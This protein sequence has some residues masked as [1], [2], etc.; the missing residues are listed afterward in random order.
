MEEN[1]ISASNSQSEPQKQVSESEKL[2]MI[3][4]ILR[5]KPRVETIE[6]TQTIEHDNEN[7]SHEKVEEKQ[8]MPHVQPVQVVKQ[9]PISFLLVC[10]LMVVCF[11]TGYLGGYFYLYKNMPTLDSNPN[12]IYVPD[13]TPANVTI[14]EIT[15][16]STITTDSDLSASIGSAIKT[17]VLVQGTTSS[18][19]SLGSGVMFGV[20]E[21]QGGESGYTYIL[22]NHHVIAD[23]NTIKIQTYT[24]KVY[25]ATLVGSSAPHDLAV[26]KVK[27]MQQ[28]D[29]STATFGISA[30]MVLGNTTI[31]IGNAL[32]EG[33]SV[34]TGIVSSINK[35]VLMDFSI[36]ELLQTDAAINQ[37][38]SGGGLFDSA[39]NLIGIVNAKAFG[40]GIEG[41][42]YA[43]P[44]DTAKDVA[45]KLLQNTIGGYGY[46]PGSVFVGI[47]AEESSAGLT[48]S[49]ADVAD[50]NKYEEN[51]LSFV[52][53]L[54]DVIT[55]VSTETADWVVLGEDVNF[56]NVAQKLKTMNVGDKLI[57]KVSRR[58]SNGIF[59]TYEEHTVTLTLQ[60][61]VYPN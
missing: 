51:G 42:G 13:N 17:V 20:S 52:F 49:S 53:R 44:V 29:I 41:L 27:D 16:D 24:N 40:T 30:N 60:Q 25:G 31:A 45:L 1:E 23:A 2:A 37:G 9:R 21:A 19:V 58:I 48:L 59:N 50:A 43:I 56:L 4:E 6:D 46:V 61:Y 18:G 22:T 3:E 35:K 47:N 11:A 38:N 5:G 57:L 33:Y 54:G 14:T 15:Q 28:E 12:T 8:E 7:I 39:G 34:T 26:I 36:Y 32:G 10:F 55:S